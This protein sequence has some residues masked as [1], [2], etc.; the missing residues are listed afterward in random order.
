MTKAPRNHVLDHRIPPPLVFLLTAVAMAGA[1]AWLP[2]SDLGGPFAWGL[3]VACVLLAGLAGPPAILRFRRARTTIDPVDIGR[4]S[5][6]VVDGPYRWTRNPMYLA[7]AAVLAAIAAFTAQPV[8]TLGVVAFCAYI[9]RY[10]IRPEERAMRS[11]F[12]AAYDAYC[13]R[14]RRWL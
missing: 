12:G 3:G 4:A 14:V 8:L 7:M 13:L 11:R 1:A 10:Q 5:S 6:L 2:A 9:T